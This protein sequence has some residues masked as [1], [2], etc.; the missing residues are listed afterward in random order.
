MKPYGLSLTFAC[1]AFATPILLSKRHRAAQLKEF[2]DDIHLQWALCDAHPSIVLAKLGYSGTSPK[3]ITPITYYDTSPPIHSSKGLM[4]RTKTSHGSA[5]ST[6]KVRFSSKEQNET[7]LELPDSVECVHDRYGSSQFYTCEQRSPLPDEEEG[8]ESPWSSGQRAFA[9][10]FHDDVEWKKLI[11]YGPFEDS[12]WKLRLPISLPFSKKNHIKAVFD[13]VLAAIPKSL[14][15]SP[16]DCDK[17]EEVR[18]LHLMEIEIKASLSHGQEVYTR[19][20]EYLQ[21]KRV[22]LC[23]EQEGKTLRLFKKMKFEV[24][25]GGEDGRWED[26]TAELQNLL[27]AGL[28]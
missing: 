13:D 15:L 16:S 10:E 5:L 9:E 4:M 2:E 17:K 3:R 28:E 7:D 23:E 14:A 12:K 27:I 1:L 26:S 24:E 25:N 8:C 18:E 19:V 11:A 21:E 22:V 6:V 20:S